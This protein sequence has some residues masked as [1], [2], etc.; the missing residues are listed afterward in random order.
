MADEN[1]EV[2]DTVWTRKQMLFVD[3]T[4]VK[5]GQ[6][7][8]IRLDRRQDVKIAALPDKSSGENCYT[9]ETHQGWQFYMR[10]DEFETVDDPRH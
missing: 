8:E 5:T 1:I 3:A 7:G 10:R 6:A 2:G 9:C 4:H